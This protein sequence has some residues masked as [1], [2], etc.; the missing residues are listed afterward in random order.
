MGE[1]DSKIVKIQAFQAIMVALIGA[2]ATII[3]AYIA[4]SSNASSKKNEIDAQKVAQIGQNSTSRDSSRALIINE[5]SANNQTSS[6]QKSNPNEGINNSQLIDFQKDVIT[7]ESQAARLINQINQNKK[8]LN[9]ELKQ[10]DDTEKFKI[11]DQIIRLDEIIQK[12]KIDQASLQKLKTT[13][14]LSPQTKNSLAE[15]IKA[16]DEIENELADF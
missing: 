15:I 8:D 2:V 1:Q 5:K 10:A 4:T 11:K 16:L 3:G 13:K 7:A 14:V 6:A 9:S 12:I